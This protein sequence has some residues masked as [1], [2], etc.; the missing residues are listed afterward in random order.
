MDVSIV[1][2]TGKGKSLLI[3]ENNYAHVF[4]V[5]S[6]IDQHINMELGTVYACVVSVTPA[7]AGNCFFYLK[8]DSILPMHLSNLRVRAVGAA[9]GIQ[10]K[11]KD[12]GTPAAGIAVTP[13]NKNTSI[14]SLAECTTEYGTNITGLSGGSIVDLLWVDA[15]ALTFKFEWASDI[16]IAKNDIVSFYAVTGSIPLIVTATIYFYNYEH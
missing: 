14:G 9:E 6:P 1:D 13:V 8:N 3:D 4:S 11:L 5:G 10:I 15:S 7:G 16:I 2:G 12:T